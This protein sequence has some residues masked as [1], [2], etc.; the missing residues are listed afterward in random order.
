MFYNRPII[1]NELVSFAT[2]Y[3]QIQ[4]ELLREL[5]IPYALLDEDGKI[6]WNNRAFSRVIHNEKAVRR[7][8]TSF[9]SPVTR[10][11][12]PS[13][14]EGCTQFE[15]SYG[16]SE[17]SAKFTRISLREA[18]SDS[19]IIEDADYKGCLFAM[20]LF[21]ETAL[22]IALKENDDQSLAVG[23]IYLDNYDEALGK[24]G[25]G[26]PVP[27]HRADREKDQQVCFRLRRA[28]AGR[29]RRTSIWW[30]W[31][32][33]A[34]AQMSEKRF[35]I[36]DDVKT[37]NIGNEMAVTISVGIGLDGLTYSQNYEFSRAAIDMAL[38]RGGDQAVVKTPEQISYLRRK[39]PAGG[40]EY[41][42]KGK[43][44]GACAA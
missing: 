26:T 22:K 19:D 23:L 35:E 29:S 37:V 39:E 8:V 41:P 5:D 9:F 43:G 42:R 25:G 4:K 27:A 18:A 6:I 31:R 32:K 28:S 14:E 16:D 33:R 7:S 40:E 30:C 3:G 17:Y 2:Q 36:L 13:E 44:E 21:D 20:Y 15:L 1:L 10:D 38:G 24:R 11:R 12:L 34:V